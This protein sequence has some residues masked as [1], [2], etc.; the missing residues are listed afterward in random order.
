MEVKHRY[1]INIKKNTSEQ[2]I[3]QYELISNHIFAKYFSLFL[4]LT[5]FQLFWN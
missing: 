3:C 4:K 2:K 1:D 5:Y